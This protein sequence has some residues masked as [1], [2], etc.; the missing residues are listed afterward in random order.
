M[1]SQLALTIHVLSVVVWL[2]CGLYELFLAHELKQARVD[3]HS[4]AS[5][6]M[7][8][9]YAAPVPRN[10]AVR[11]WSWRPWRSLGLLRNFRGSESSRACMVA[12]LSSL[13]QSCRRSEVSVGSEALP[14]TPLNSAECRRTVQRHRALAVGHARS[15]YHCCRLCNLAPPHV[16]SCRLTNVGADPPD[17][18]QICIRKFAACLA[19]G[20]TRLLGV[21]VLCNARFTEHQMR[22][23][24]TKV[25]LAIESLL[26]CTS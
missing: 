7:Y 18:H 9:K 4:G 6:R 13:R 1:L 17:S 2:G 8:L 23:Y 20:S 19:G 21:T 22:E 25:V 26:G 5:L 12:V 24:A 16:P 11:Y 3:S 15:G 10:V 14:K